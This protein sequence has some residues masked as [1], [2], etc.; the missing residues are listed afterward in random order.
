MAQLK[1]IR[2]TIAR[3]A[4]RAIKAPDGEASQKIGFETW[5]TFRYDT[6]LAGPGALVTFRHHATDIVEA[7]IR[8]GG[9]ANG[10]TR[11]YRLTVSNG[12]FRSMVTYGRLRDIL[13]A[14]G[15]GIG[16][17][18]GRA[19][20]AG[21]Q[22]FARN[23]EWNQ[24][25]HRSVTIWFNE[26][27]SFH[28]S[29][30]D[31]GRAY[32]DADEIAALDWLRNLIVTDDPEARPVLAETFRAALANAP[33]HMGYPG[34]NAEERANYMYGRHVSADYLLSTFN[35]LRRSCFAQHYG[36]PESREA[37]DFLLQ[38]WREAGSP[39]PAKAAR[40]RF[41]AEA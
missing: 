26:D 23:H 27:G 34:V 9:L 36:K 7:H 6:S 5:V 3:L 29:R 19:A 25:L 30:D 16:R 39:S 41:P 14:F 21:D 1:D 8:P 12:G 32:P 40:Q 20:E 11:L 22:V 2:A 17:R 4:D 31:G 35:G 13:G 18:E 15:A 38:E 28:A 37:L 33:G 10:A 24:P